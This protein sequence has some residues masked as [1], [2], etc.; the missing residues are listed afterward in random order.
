MMPG[1]YCNNNDLRS[2]PVIGIRCARSNSSSGEGGGTFSKPYT[3]ITK[4]NAK[5]RP[6]QKGTQN[7]DI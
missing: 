6:V 1:K 5:T 3:Q 4:G 7:S 2:A